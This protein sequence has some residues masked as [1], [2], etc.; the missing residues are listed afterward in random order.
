[1]NPAEVYPLI[2]IP[3]YDGTCQL[4]TLEAVQLSSRRWEPKIVTQ[5]SSALGNCFNRLWVTA[6]NS[7]AGGITHFAMLHSDVIPEVGW[8]DKMMDIMADKGADVLSVIIP[9]KSTEGLTSTALDTGGRW[10]VNRFTMKQVH[11]MPATFTHPKL[12]LNTGLMLVDLRKPWVERVYF[13]IRD[14]IVR[15]ESGRFRPVMMSEDWDFSRQ[16][17]ALEAKLWATREVSVRHVGRA[18]YGNDSAWGSM[19]VDTVNGEARL[20]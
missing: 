9:I 2:A 4:D 19:E 10:K 13:T 3:S 20:I 15:D 18:L 1:M 14:S 6:L 17:T 5:R 16:A 8:L 11:K 7:R 12:L